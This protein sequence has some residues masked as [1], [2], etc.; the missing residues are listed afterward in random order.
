MDLNME[1][2]LTTGDCLITSILSPHLTENSGHVP[3]KDQPVSDVLGNI[4]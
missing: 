1:N 4:I 3:S 2:T